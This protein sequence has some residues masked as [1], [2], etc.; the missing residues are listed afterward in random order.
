[1]TGPVQPQPPQPMQYA[2]SPPSRML[3]PGS[4]P[5]MPVQPSFTSAPGTFPSAPQAGAV[6]IPRSM[7]VSSSQ[8]NVP[9]PPRTVQ[10][11]G[12]L[13]MPPTLSPAS[14]LSPSHSQHSLNDRTIHAQNH[15]APL[16]TLMP[17]PKGPQSVST[18]GQSNGYVNNDLMRASS[19]T[20]S[21]K[22]ET[23]GRPPSSMVSTL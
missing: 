15:A 1:M 6:N 14:A 13:I 16:P 7:N 21:Q 3:P 11:S 12:P 9:F 19:F 8:P 4:G 18:N 2:G 10:S 5:S 17:V 20:S 22:M 23:D